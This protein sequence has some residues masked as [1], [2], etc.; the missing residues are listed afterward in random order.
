MA[1]IYAI[2]DTVS[3]RVLYVGSTCEKRYQ[4][5]WQNHMSDLRTGRH[6][7]NRLLNFFN[8]F[9][10]KALEFVKVCS[11]SKKDVTD[12][13]RFY[14]KELGAPFNIKMNRRKH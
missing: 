2:K 14:I 1:T 9:G 11:C 3:N 4:R 13:E 7:N 5:R 8:R 10:E 12:L 6:P